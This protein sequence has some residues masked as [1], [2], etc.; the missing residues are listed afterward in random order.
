MILQPSA[1]TDGFEYLPAPVDDRRSTSRTRTV[2]RVARVRTHDDEGLARIRNISDGG[3]R[4]TIG[5]PVVAGDTIEVSMSDALAFKGR[6]I[7]AENGE[8]GIQFAEWVDSVEALRITS[9]EA[10]EKSHRPPRLSASQPAVVMTE[11]GLQVTHLHD[12]S[13]RGVKIA[14]DGSFT[15]GLPVKVIIG[16]GVERRGCV[17]WVH[18]SFAGVILTEP[19]TVEELGSVS[20]L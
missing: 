6:V 11:R 18:E 14:H 10:R 20:G 12:I 13:Q 2:Y 3:M 8:C 4:L 1:L 17:R 7:W 19:F 9:V 15:P 5:I 16:P